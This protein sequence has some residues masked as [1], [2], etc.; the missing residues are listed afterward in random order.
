[1]AGFGVGIGNDLGGRCGPGMIWNS[2]LN[3]CVYIMEKGESK[4]NPTKPSRSVVNGAG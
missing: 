2:R 1:M 4:K 3:R